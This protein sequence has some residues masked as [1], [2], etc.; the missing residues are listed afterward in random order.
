MSLRN[1]LDFALRQRLTWSPPARERSGEPEPF[2][3]DRE[4]LWTETFGLG[5]AR[6]RM[7]AWRWRRNLDALGLLVRAGDHP[8]VEALRRRRG[9][10]RVLDV[11]SKNFDYADALSAFWTTG[12]VPP[13]LTGIELD[14][15][16]RYTDFRTR[17]AWAEHYASFVPD[18]RYVAGDVLAWTEPADAVT[19]FYPFLTRG[20]LNRWGLPA[21]FL[22]PRDLLDHVAGL[23]SPGGV[24]LIANLNDDEAALQRA[25][26]EEAGL[27]HS[28][29]GAVPGASA[30]ASS[31]RRLIVVTT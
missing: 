18:A 16:R 17:R 1:A 22:R 10:L 5:P 13:R 23:V 9:P 27:P 29:L 30:A 6:K 19:W 31:G 4:R 25:L 2:A 7:A 20:P 15:H 3:D 12:G 28:D 24:L 11:G 26:L 21:R 14:A 8:A